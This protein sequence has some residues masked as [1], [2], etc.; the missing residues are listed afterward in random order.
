MGIGQEIRIAT[1]KN[2]RAGDEHGDFTAGEPFGFG[3]GFP[4]FENFIAL[5]VGLLTGCAGGLG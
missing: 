1:G 5:T 2:P 4:D 3:K